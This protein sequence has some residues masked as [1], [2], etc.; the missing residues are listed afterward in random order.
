MSTKLAE[1]EGL[2]KTW[3]PKAIRKNGRGIRIMTFSGDLLMDTHVTRLQDMVRALS[4]MLP[5]DTTLWVDD[6]QVIRMR[7]SAGAYF[8]QYVVGF[9]SKEWKGPEPGN[10][11]PEIK[12]TFSE[13]EGG[14]LVCESII[15]VENDPYSLLHKENIALKA[16]YERVRLDRD[17]LQEATARLR[18]R[19]AELDEKIYFLRNPDK[20]PK[21][22]G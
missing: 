11:I 20:Q 17:R 7:T 10:Y 5:D 4:V 2:F 15:E 8:D 1:I 14:A 6:G 9:T 22:K 19:I 18:A 16:D 3:F 12:A 21:C 13:V